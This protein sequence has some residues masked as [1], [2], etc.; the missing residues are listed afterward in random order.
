MDGRREREGGKKKR[1]LSG[2]I[3]HKKCSRSWNEGGG[4]PGGLDDRLPLLLR[5]L[6]YIRTE[7]S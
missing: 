2:G 5:R 3:R 1:S 7:L 4:F 6:A